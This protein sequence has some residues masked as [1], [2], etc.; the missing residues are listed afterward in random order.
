MDSVLDLITSFGWWPNVAQMAF[1]LPYVGQA[2][3]HVLVFLW[4]F[5]G[6]YV[7][8][9]GVYRAHLSGRLSR[10][11][12]AFG[13]PWVVIGYLVDVVANIFVA[14]LLFL[15]LPRELLV[16]DRLQRYI[17]TEGTSAWRRSIAVWV[18]DDLLD[19]FDPSGDHC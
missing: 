15:E 5:W 17:K 10:A 4:V 11:A 14:T 12:Y 1:K 19:I 6:L 9:M 13:L 7:L 8:V 3:L 18:C 16:T 2:L